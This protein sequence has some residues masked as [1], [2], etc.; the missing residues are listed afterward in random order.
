MAKSDEKTAHAVHVI[1]GDDDYLVNQEARSVVDACCPKAEQELN[2][3]IVDGAVEV[4]DEASEALAKA[5]EAVQTVGLFGG[6]K[7]VW[8]RNASIFGADVLGKSERLKPLKEALTGLIK[9][10]LPDG[11]VLV[12]SALKVDGRGA[13]VKACKAHARYVEFKTPERE[14]EA[15]QSAEDRT[16]QIWRELELK[17]DSRRVVDAFLEMVGSDTRRIV[18]ESEKLVAYL[19]AGQ[20]TVSMDDVQA[21]I[22]P[23][24]ESIVWAL[25]DQVAGRNMTAALRVLKQLLFQRENPIGLIIGLENR[26][27]ELAV[28]KECIRRNWLRLESGGR[29]AKPAWHVDAEGEEALSALAR[30]P[31]QMHPYRVGMLVDQAQRFTLRE[32]LL[33]QKDLADTHEK[34]VSSS[35]PQA[36]ALEFLIIRL[37]QGASSAAS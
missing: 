37:T 26:F 35:L 21:V 23:G 28:L 1:T 19:G 20:R 2:L 33:A 18:Q 13:F 12:I 15:N 30:D 22:S 34:L 17:P 8:L 9:K 29:Y 5:L 4:I 10:G 16:A 11:H 3:E 32:L 7:V 36:L 25:A 6:R 27:R 31:R 24:R 14:R